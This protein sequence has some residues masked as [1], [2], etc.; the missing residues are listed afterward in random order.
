M[1]KKSPSLNK[2]LSKI[3]DEIVAHESKTVCFISAT[4]KEG[5]TSIA[6]GVAQLAVALNKK[7]L[8]CDFCDYETSLSKT[9]KQEFRKSKSADLAQISKNIHLIEPL[10]FYLLPPPQPL[11][12]T[13]LQKGV[14][15]DLM[16]QFKKEYD[17]IVIDTN[18]FDGYVED[19]PSAQSLIQVAEATVL[20]VLS[21]G[22]PEATVKNVADKIIHEGGKLIG[23]IMNDIQYPKLVDDLSRASHHLDG[24][25]PSGSEKFRKW[26]KGSS[27]LNIEI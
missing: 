4:P 15:A 9:L 7:V 16:K 25:L 22:V 21:G 13:L 23:I 19:L 3:Y 12:A 17:L 18:H 10:G 2:S 1:T 8:F 26:V 5:T 11:Y 6:R 20:V 27:L 14:L 24:I